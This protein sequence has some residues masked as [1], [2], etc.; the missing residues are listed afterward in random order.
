MPYWLKANGLSIG[1]G[2]LFLATL[3]GQA[4]S[5]HD[6]VN[7]DSL[8]HQGDPM[9]LGHYV[10]SALFW[11]D[12]ME[13]WQ[14]EYLQFSLYIFT[15]VWLVQ[16]GSN[17]SKELNRTGAESDE[18]QKVGAHA[19]PDS[20]RWARAGDWRTRIYS[21]SLLLVMMSIWVA[22]WLAQSL[23]GRV[24]YNAN[25][26]DHQAAPISWLSYITTAD[27]WNRTLQNWQ[28][29]FLAVGSMVILSVYLRQRGS[30][31]SKPVG[32]AHDAT[33]AEG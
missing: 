17:E 14:S 18:E 11:A 32:A 28:S 30:P 12:V 2:L 9:S 10:T 26:L 13:N 29:E 15:T 19:T 33:A 16:R 27:F 22:S 7:H 23:T 1:F 4:I 31:E 3:V 6:S 24:N 8:L 21:N 5:G 25:Q 20:P